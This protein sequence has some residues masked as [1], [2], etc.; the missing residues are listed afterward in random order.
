MEFVDFRCKAISRDIATLFP[1]WERGET[2]AFLSPHDDDVVLGGGYLV[3]AVRKSGGQV[4]VFIFCQGDAGYSSLS[5]K[6]TIVRTRR[7]EAITSYGILGVQPSRIH[8]LGL[9]DLSVMTYVNRRVFGHKGLPDELL[10]LFRRHRISRA[11]FS[12]PHFENWDHTAV[13]D[14]GMYVVPQ[15]GDPV[16]ADLGKAFPVRSSLV[17]SVW[18][19]FGPASPDSVSLKA[20]V[21]IL[22]GEKEER[23]VRK[24]LRAFASQAEIMENTVARHRNS[25]S[26]PGGHLELFQRPRLR[27]P[28][29]YA[30]YFEIIKR[31]QHVRHRD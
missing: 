20:D 8:F 19:D 18:G 15:A 11:V 3:Q 25:R 9:P 10:K 27:E 16:L 26:G 24:A 23:L 30:P 31:G 22:A 12:S 21:G 6:R 17:Y 5:A 13:Y 7:R 4:R 2:V 1:G 28:I 29:D 14:I